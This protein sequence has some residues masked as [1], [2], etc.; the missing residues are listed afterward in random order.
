MKLSYKGLLTIFMVFAIGLVK[1]TQVSA[2]DLHLERLLKVFDEQQTAE[3]ANEFLDSLKGRA[4]FEIPIRFT[5]EHAKDT[6][7]QQVWYWAA[8]YYYDR[9]HY[10]QAV[11]YALRSLPLQHN[12]TELS[13]CLNLIAISYLRLGDYHEAAR[14]AKRCYEMDKESGDIDRVSSSLNTLSAIYI[15]ARQPSEAEK[16]VLRG[17]ELS[18]QVDNPGRLAILLGKASEVYHQLADDSKSLDYARQAYQLERQ[19]GR[20]E[21]IGIRLSQMA[22][23]YIGLKQPTIARDTLRKAIPILEAAGNRQQLGIC[24]NQ[25][26]GLLLGEKK[27]SEA[28]GYFERAYLLFSNLGDRYNESIALNGLSKS[29]RD[30]DP[31]RAMSFMERYNELK[32]SIYDRETGQ[33]LSEY[34]AQYGYEQLQLEN[35]MAQ[36]DV[37]SVVIVAIGGFLV[38]L[39]AGIL[40]TIY[41]RRRTQRLH[42]EMEQRLDALKQD[43]DQLNSQYANIISPKVSSDDVDENLSD[44]DRQFLSRTISI[45][46]KQLDEGHVNVDDVASELCLSTSQFRRRL[47]ALT[48]ETPK[49]YIQAIRM[50]KALHL[51]DTQPTMPVA[52]VALQCGYD[53]NTN[54]TRAFKRFY[55]ITPSEYQSGRRL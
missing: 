45:I 19:L 34:A 47:S 26:G 35:Q 51:L 14:Y 46:N 54:F 5:G 3:V 49:N 40:F 6:V 27:Q 21:R 13:D 17:I 36:R 12:K 25:M 41:H 24:Y 37:R 50:Q 42:V 16:Y 10:D 30:I 23:A 4:F 48:K 52:E 43:Y 18:R 9:Q 22:S 8:E 28:A 29:L 44:E 53:E 1:P 38:M 39:L 7:R 20:E 55:G 11:S 33:L 15:G 32:D 2:D 31:A